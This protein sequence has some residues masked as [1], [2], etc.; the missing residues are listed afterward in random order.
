MYA[1]GVKEPV[2]VKNAAEAVKTMQQVSY[3]S[4]WDARFAIKRESVQNAAVMDGHHIN[5][6]EG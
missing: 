6:E 4:R 1:L 5:A 3:Y 2:F